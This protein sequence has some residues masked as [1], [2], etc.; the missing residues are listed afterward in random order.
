MEPLIEFSVDKTNV[1]VGDIVLIKWNCGCEDGRAE[2][3]INNGYK[4]S[5]ETVEKVG[6]K[7]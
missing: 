1:T 6:S 4:Q 2:L 7:R 5:T 3:T